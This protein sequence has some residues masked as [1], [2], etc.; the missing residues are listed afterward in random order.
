MKTYLLSLFLMGTSL[1]AQQNVHK[2]YTN[3]Y[4]DYLEQQNPNLKAAVHNTFEM[5]QE[6]GAHQSHP[7]ATNG[8]FDTIYRVPVVFHVVYNGSIQNV[9]TSLLESQIEVL[10]E[11]FNRLNSDTS[12]TRPL[13]KDRAS[14]VGFEY[15][16]A[17]IDP[18]GNPTSGITRTP[19]TATFS[20]FNLDDMKKAG[21]GKEAWDTDEYLNIWVCDL[22]GL[23]LGF[24]YPP[25]V[26]PNWPAGQTPSSAA[27]EGV[28]IHYEVIGRN[29]PLA[30]GQLAIANKGRTAVHEV[31][32]F[33]GLRHIWGDSGNPFSTAPDCDL[34]KDDGFSDTPHMG[35]NSQSTGCSFSKNSCTNGESPDEPD[36]V[37]NYMDYST[38]TCQN[39]FTEQQANLMRSMAVIGRPN[40]PNLVIDE[41][42]NVALGQWVVV[43]NTDTFFLDGNSLVNINAGDQVMFLNQNNGFNYTA[44]DNYALNANDE[45]SLT[46]T[47]NVSFNQGPNGIKENLGRL[48][49]VYPNPANDFIEISNPSALNF[50]HVSIISITGQQ[51]LQQPINSSQLKIST[52]TLNNGVYF[53]QFKNQSEVIGVKKLNILR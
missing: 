37:E 46:E 39:M 52:Q 29:N 24:A 9:P 27:F 53:L 41:T 23:I 15:F 51:L 3:E 13:F 33:W 40:I 26:A 7:K 32:H 42:F 48:I 4:L 5:A 2:C 31:G 50:N 14:G 1:F 38:E 22:G 30:V 17:T 45:A 44:T 34:T 16:L 12:N 20:F 28:V 43:N 47:G 36:M 11:D 10:N 25:A 18:D 6:Y 19:T 49:K 35:N 21:T 8:I